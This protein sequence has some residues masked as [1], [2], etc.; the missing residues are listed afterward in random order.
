MY[1]GENL[2]AQWEIK[3]K[4]VY[5]DDFVKN[6]NLQGGKKREEEKTV[7]EKLR[8]RRNFNEEGSSRVLVIGEL[9]CRL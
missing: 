3:E 6:S 7:E 2:L 4:T 5:L 8:K 1:N 9:Y